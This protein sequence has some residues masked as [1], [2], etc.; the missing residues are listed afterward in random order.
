MI[1]RLFDSIQAEEEVNY[2][3]DVMS[4]KITMP[5]PIQDSKLF[6]CT[7]SIP[8]AFD[9]QSMDE[10]TFGEF[11]S[12]VTEIEF[13]DNRIAVS[14]REIG[15]GGVGVRAVEKGSAE[16]ATVLEMRQLRLQNDSIFEKTFSHV[17]AAKFRNLCESETGEF[18]SGN[19]LRKIRGKYC[20]LT[21]M[22]LEEVEAVPLW[23]VLEMMRSQPESIRTGEVE[24]P[25]ELKASLAKFNA[26]FPDP[27]K[28]GF[29]MMEF[30]GTDRHKRIVDAIQ[31]AF[32]EFEITIVTAEHKDY[33]D[34]LFPNVKTYMHGCGFGVALFDRLRNELF[35]PNASLEIGYMLALGKKVLLLKD[36]SLPSLHSDLVGELYKSFDVEKPFETIGP[37]VA[38]WLSDRNIVKPFQDLMIQI[39]GRWEL[40]F[41]NSGSESLEIWPDGT[42]TTRNGTKL[43]VKITE[44]NGFEFEWQK[45]LKKGKHQF[46]LLTISNDLNR[47]IGKVKGGHSLEYV[48]TL[49]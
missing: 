48:R 1:C 31:K 20:E 17:V 22:T 35:N 44:R 8:N 24:A 13:N 36:H 2:I 14:R 12:A 23:E 15:D 32:R 9:E 41:G 6:S 49:A 25:D 19:Y 21:G 34:S 33:N 5:Y 3:K 4:D 26:E 38:K 30:G 39:A 43:S 46:E 16:A 11:F 42:Y 28:I 10:L 7:A 27:M 18:P 45:Q 37:A 29:L 40:T 47:M